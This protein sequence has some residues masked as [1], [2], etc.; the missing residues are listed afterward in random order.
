[1][2]WGAVASAVRAADVV[3]SGGGGLLQS[4]TSLRSLLYYA[5]IIREAKRAGRKAVIFAQG[6]G[7]L[8]YFGREVVKRACAHVDLATVRDETSQGTLA[9]LLP[10]VQVRLSADPV[11]LAPAEASAATR[12]S[13]AR[14]GL[15]DDLGELVAVVVRRG[16][17]LDQV[18]E[19]LAAVVDRLALMYGAN[20]VFVPLQPPH[21]ADAAAA[22]IRRCKSTPVLMTGGYDLP[23]MTALLARCSAVISM[24]LHALILAARLGVPFLSVPY[25]PKIG[26]LANSL[27][28]PLAPLARDSRADELTDHLWLQR[29]ALRAHL[30]ERVPALQARAALAFDWL[31]ALVEGAPLPER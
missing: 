1:M 22:V 7:P 2:A 15:R 23:A 10:N 26:A 16:P 25:D 30:G 17:A 6:I 31:Q 19:K 28:Y 13:L 9:A 14:E 5:S 4:A 27:A 20:V 8:N 18:M 29:D 21:D 24:R 11:F 12:Q 3:V